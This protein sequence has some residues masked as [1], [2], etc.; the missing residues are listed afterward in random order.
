MERFKHD[1]QQA[2]NVYTIWVTPALA[3]A[4][5][6]HN[7]HNRSAAKRPIAVYQ[8]DMDALAWRETGETVSWTGQFTPDYP[9]VE[10]DAVLL[11]GGHRLFAASESAEGFPVYVVYDIPLAGQDKMDR[12]R[13]RTYADQLGLH[14]ESASVSL[15][16]IARRFY[17]WESG[18]RLFT[19]NLAAQMNTDTDLDN[20]IV[21]NPDMR[22]AARFAVSTKVDNLPSSLVGLAYLLFRRIDAEDCDEFFRRLSKGVDLKEDSPIWHLRERLAQFATGQTKPREGFLFAHVIKAWNQFRDGA[23]VTNFRIRTGGAAP[24]AFPEPH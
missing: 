15:A 4:W 19:S 13:K 5:L 8:K 11:N 16:A 23:S 3:K 21:A 22:D 7:T 17:G 14:G 12:G 2:T 9:Y 10:D 6:E 1:P 20:L 24:E 18:R